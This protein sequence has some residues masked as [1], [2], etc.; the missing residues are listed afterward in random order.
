MPIQTAGFS[1]NPSLLEGVRSAASG[2]GQSA[3]PLRFIDGASLLPGDNGVALVAAGNVARQNSVQQ[4]LQDLML[5]FGNAGRALREDKKDKKEEALLEKK[6]GDQQAANAAKLEWDKEKFYEGQK[7][8]PLS[9]LDEARI[10]SLDAETALLARPSP[11]DSLVKGTKSSD[12]P[13][14]FEPEKPLSLL[15]ASTVQA[16][17]PAM[18]ESNAAIP[19]SLGNVR[20]PQLNGD[21]FLSE[22]PA[23]ISPEAQ[24]MP[25]SRA[26]REIPKEATSEKVG[27]ENLGAGV[28]QL[29]L[30]GGRKLYVTPDS[31]S[32]T[33]WKPIPGM[34]EKASAPEGVLTEDQQKIVNTIND[35]IAKYTQIPAA[36]DAVGSYGIV[37]ANLAAQNGTSD[38]TAIN[39]FQRMVDPGVAVREGDVA[40]IQKAIPRMQSWG[41]K[42]KNLVVG[43]QLSPEVRQQMLDAAKRMVTARVNT[44]KPFVNKVRERA[45]RSGVDP[46]LVLDP[47]QL[48]GGLMPEISSQAE[49]DKLDSGAAFIWRGKSG[50]KP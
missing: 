41:L 15:K 38:I 28:F 31:K 26:S 27:V 11:F 3:S 19:M 35:D 29:M 10:R 46:D 6:Y 30:P 50:V 39:A 25:D 1:F 43:D 12:V 22:T 20:I 4:G 9:A 8:G 18:L 48:P 44:A 13:K 42:A 49:Y 23:Q 36:Y 5:A 2:G 16:A 14:D 7:P 37:E 45:R 33:G 40:L 17:A 32:A 24:L 34:S 47:I 21:N